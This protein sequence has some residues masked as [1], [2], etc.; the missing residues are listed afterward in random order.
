[1]TEKNKMLSG[2]KRLLFVVAENIEDEAV[3]GECVKKIM[4]LVEDEA[5]RIAKRLLETLTYREQEVSKLRLGVFDEFDYTTE[6]V[7]R[8]FKVSSERIRQVEAKARRKL[9]HL[10][11]LEILREELRIG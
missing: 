9:H 5:D 8:L 3:K 11:K 1:M 10:N 6:E 4:G 7:A 2:S